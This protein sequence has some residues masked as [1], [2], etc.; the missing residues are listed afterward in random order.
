M[1]MRKTVSDVRA[2][3]DAHA[4]EIRGDLER[5]ASLLTVTLIAVAAMATFAVFYAVSKS[6]GNGHNG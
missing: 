2:D 4:V 3:V 5:V 1:F 6:E